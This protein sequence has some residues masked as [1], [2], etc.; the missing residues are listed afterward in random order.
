MQKVTIPTE[1]GEITVLPGHQ[2]LISVVAS[3]LLRLVPEEM[4]AMDQ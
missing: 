2:P 3:G 4:P 1:I